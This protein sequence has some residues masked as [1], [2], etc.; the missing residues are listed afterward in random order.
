[1][2]SA[3]TFL[4]KNKRIGRRDARINTSAAASCIVKSITVI[5]KQACSKLK[6]P[7]RA[8]LGSRSLQAASARCSRTP[9]INSAPISAEPSRA[10]RTRESADTA[11]EP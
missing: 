11:A 7:T 9:R 4:D 6:S 3:R 8:S 5:T 2:R 1:M 10:P